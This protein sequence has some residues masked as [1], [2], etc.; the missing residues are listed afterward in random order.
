MSSTYAG[1]GVKRALWQLSL[2]MVFKGLITVFTFGMKVRIL[3]RSRNEK[4]CVLH[5][6]KTKMQ[7]SWAVR[8][9]FHYIDSTIP[10]L[11][12]C[13]ISSR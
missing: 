5:L 7:I 2:A 6:R 8:L 4:T 11:P 10:L 13:K 3:Y 1:D 9:C 12:K